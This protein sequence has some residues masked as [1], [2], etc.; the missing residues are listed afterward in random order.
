MKRLVLLLV[1][2]LIGLGPA[3]AGSAHAGRQPLKSVDTL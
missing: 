1:V 2:A 3:A